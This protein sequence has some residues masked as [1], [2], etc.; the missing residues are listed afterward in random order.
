MSGRK[1]EC[2]SLLLFNSVVAVCVKR[3]EGTVLVISVF[4]FKKHSLFFFFFFNVSFKK[5]SPY[6]FF[7][8]S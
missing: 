2:L 3:T 5:S 8:K 1:P 4:H 7:K 6:F